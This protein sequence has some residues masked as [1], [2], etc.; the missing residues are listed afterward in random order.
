MPWTEIL[1]PALIIV[2]LLL[3]N[4]FFV[5][6]EF[7]IVSAS[8][9]A[10]QQ[11]VARGSRRAIQV[12][13]VKDS[14]LLQDQYIATAQL[15]ITLATLGLGMYGEHQ[16]AHGIDHLF[17]L[18][19][20]LQMIASHS[21]A[22][23]ISITLMTY[24][25][26]VI[27]ETIPKSLA[28]QKAETLVL[29]INPVMQVIRN[30]MLPFVWLLNTTGNALLRRAGVDRA[31]GEGESHTLNDFHFIVDESQR[32]G[33]LPREAAEML[34]ELLDFNNLRANE[35]MVPRVRLTGI[36]VGCSPS[37]IRTLLRSEAHTRYPLYKGDPDHILG[38][39]H[40][41]DLLKRLQTGKT[42]TARDARP[43]P[44][45]PASADLAAVVR[46]MN[47]YQT[48]MVVVLDEYGGTAGIITLEDL[49]ME[50]VGDIGEEAGDAPDLRPDSEGHLLAEGTVHL[51]E[52]GEYFDRELEHEEVDTVSGLV[53]DLLERPPVVG[54]SV[55][56]EGLEFQVIAI[57]GHGVKTC[58]VI[59]MHI[60]EQDVE[61]E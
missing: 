32:A 58:R 27:G 7:A 17:H 51:D 4:G 33:A 14:P 40:I 46:S 49:F 16:L 26:V 24:F 44:Y 41:K 12:A 9:T 6:A 52:V 45:L 1:I 13:R 39:I 61:D 11:M 3:L 34:H 35:V 8:R 60:P 20:P 5:A 2:V 31:N 28:I 50:I 30:L 55:I 59:S 21:L 18:W 43:V 56:Y 38:F 23:V 48:Q 57:E 36:P 47:Q 54:D 53:L 42:I 22:T 29:Y 25:H 19:E 15:G 37:E 10:I